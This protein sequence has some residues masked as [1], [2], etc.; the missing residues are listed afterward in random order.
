MSSRFEFHKPIGRQRLRNF[1]ALDHLTAQLPLLEIKPYKEIVRI[2]TAYDAQR[3]CGTY[4][5]VHWNGLVTTVTVYPSGEKLE[6]VNR[7]A[8]KCDTHKRKRAKERVDA[9]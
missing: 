6:K 3:L 2:W 5:E 7:P 1:V 4:T 9:K 8:D